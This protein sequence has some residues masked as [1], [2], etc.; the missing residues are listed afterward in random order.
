MHRL[1][2]QPEPGMPATQEADTLRQSASPVSPS[3]VMTT[4]S[5]SQAG[6]LWR[7]GLDV[8][9]WTSSRGMQLF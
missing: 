1:S 8:A 6:I 7:Q 5:P 9:G 3:W 2:H 4:A